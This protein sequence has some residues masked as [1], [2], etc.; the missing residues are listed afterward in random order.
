MVL[1]I[2]T[3]SGEVSVVKYHYVRMNVLSKVDVQWMVVYVI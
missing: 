1:V 2:V 3:T